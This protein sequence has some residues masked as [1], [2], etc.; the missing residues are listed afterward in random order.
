MP[1]LR[2]YSHA[3]VVLWGPWFLVVTPLGGIQLLGRGN[4]PLQ[5]LQSFSV[6]VTYDFSFLLVASCPIALILTRCL[7]DQSGRRHKEGYR[8][9]VINRSCLTLCQSCTESYSR[10]FLAAKQMLRNVI[11]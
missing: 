3:T 6:I 11:S 1:V 7:A 2:A 8:T 4:L 5:D 10:N 9:L